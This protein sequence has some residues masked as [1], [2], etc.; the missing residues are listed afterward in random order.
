MH[1]IKSKEM[2]KHTFMPFGN[3]KE[4]MNG[5][6][7]NNKE[8]PSGYPIM[9]GK[10]RNNGESIY[11][12]L[13][14]GEF[15]IEKESL[16]VDAKGHLVSTAHPEGL[17]DKIS[18]DFSEGQVEFISGV[19]DRLETACDEICDLQCIVEGAI[20]NRPDGGEYIW[21]YSNPPL[22]QEEQNIRIAEF[23]GEKKEKTTYREY[24]AEKYGKVKMLF[25]GVH[26]NYSM[27]KAF[28]EFLQKKV[29]E[30]S[31]LDLK[32]EWYVKLV[33]VLLSDSWLIV[34]LTSASPV[35]DPGFLKG[36]GVPEEEWESYASFRNSPYGYWNLFLPELSYT[37]F[38]SYLNSIA[39]YIREGD[40]CSVQELYYPIRLKPAGENSL[41][42]LRKS[43]VN[44]IELRMLDLNPMCCAGVARRD[45]VFIHLLIA[46]RTAGLLRLWERENSD[47]DM[48]F[49][50]GLSERERLILHRQASRS[51]FWEENPDYQKRALN[52]LSDMKD[53]YEEYEKEGGFIPADYEISEVIEFQR[54][55]VLNPENRY[56]AQ[57]QKKYQPDYIGGRMREIFM[58]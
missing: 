50:E 22:F 44:H 24:L 27:P 37:D 17:S 15:G 40:I 43:G 30:Q 25:S 32:S 13:L 7:R 4:T 26:F 12:Q 39:G 11:Q 47:R 52:L 9:R 8:I 58:N 5:K 57:I 1:Y 34:A 10:T 18:R 42:N 41:E 28:F 55:K 3:F 48:V 45:L 36:L 21:T 56:C 33:D 2:L 35:A 20:L 6:E 31:L 51:R 14:D 19:Y 46:F 53:F 49:G 16:R 54:Q 23:L 29:Q 38:E